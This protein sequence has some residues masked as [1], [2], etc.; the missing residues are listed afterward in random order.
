MKRNA[1]DKEN[2]ISTDGINTN[3]PK[4]DIA[5]EWH[6]RAFGSS[7]KRFRL[8]MIII[9]G[10]I[11]TEQTKDI[12]KQ[13]AITISAFVESL[14]TKVIIIENKRVNIFPQFSFYITKVVSPISPVDT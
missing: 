1:V 3:P 4:R 8:D 5:A 9:L 11:N 13:S 6:F 10:S 12:K 7:Y 2:A 14:C